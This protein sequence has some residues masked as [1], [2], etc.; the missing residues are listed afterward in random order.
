MRRESGVVKSWG[1]K[2]WR[3]GRAEPSQELGPGRVG[4]L[5]PA[6]SGAE[7]SQESRGRRP[8]PGGFV[9]E[10]GLEMSGVVVAIGCI[11]YECLE[12]GSIFMQLLCLVIE[13]GCYKVCMLI[14]FRCASEDSRG[15]RGLQVCRSEV[16]T[17]VYTGNLLVV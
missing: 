8:G 14:L 1:A 6:K 4:S 11:V 17:S 16:E 5:G 13:S 9:L 7:P 3:S 12:H 10:I 2:S 15:S